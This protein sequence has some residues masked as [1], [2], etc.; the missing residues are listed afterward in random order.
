MTL[1][2]QIL[3]TMD[4]LRII[5]QPGYPV[6]HNG[7]IDGGDS[8]NRMGHYHFLIEANKDIKNDLA[9]LEDLPDRTIEHFNK[10]MALFECPN[11][12]GNYRRHPTN[13]WASFCNG[14]YDGVMSRDQ[15]I[16]TVISLGYTK[17]YK[18]LTMFF[19]RHLMRGLLFTTNTRKNAPNPEEFKKKKRPDF[20][21]PKSWALYLRGFPI[22]GYMLYPL[23][24]VLDLFLLAGSIVWLF[25]RQDKDIIN[26]TAILIFSR[27]RV[28][29]P[30]SWLASKILSKEYVLDKLTSY[31]CDWRKSCYFV[32]L[33]RPLVNKFMR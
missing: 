20:T 31:W 7:G 32:D 14:T 10:K 4:T 12:K 5:G 6:D 21:G 16:P 26:H 1:R 2:D 23:L 13:G 30:I 19:L 27:L 28:P 29:T 25:R 9:E 33:Y 11:S 17:N 22:L 8:I 24:C 15:S 18:R 3:K